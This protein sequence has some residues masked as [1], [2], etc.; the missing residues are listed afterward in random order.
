MLPISDSV[1]SRVFPIINILLIA[2]NAFVFYLQL[3]TPDPEGFIFT[4]A[5]VPSLIDFSDISTL[6]P[7]ITSMF[8]HGGFLHIGSN[9]LFLWVFGDNIEGELSPFTY[10]LLYLGS[11]IIGGLAQ[12]FF[13]PDSNI[14]MLG[15]SGAVAGVLGAYF[16]LFPKHEI[17]TLIFIPPFITIAKVSALIMLGYWIILQFFSGFGAL[18]MEMAEVGGVAYFAHIG[19]FIAGALL[20]KFLPKHSGNEGN[21]ES[22]IMS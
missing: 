5:L 8:L 11:G 2:I 20:I 13:V 18:G 6:Y 21:Y 12:Y 16:L 3:T 15:A 7:F 22:G 10:L 14:P 17:R 9:M 1:K 4:Y 19:G